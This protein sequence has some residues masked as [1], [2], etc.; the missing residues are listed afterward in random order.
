MVSLFSITRG[1]SLLRTL[2]LFVTLVIQQR[3][4]PIGVILEIRALDS[5][6][7]FG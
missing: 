2:E 6:Q 7:Y 3:K 4:E 5:N 1:A